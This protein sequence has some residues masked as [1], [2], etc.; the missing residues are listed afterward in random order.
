MYCCIPLILRSYFKECTIIDLSV[1]KK[2]PK[3]SPFYFWI[4]DTY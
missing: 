3:V 1:L 2:Y 4:R